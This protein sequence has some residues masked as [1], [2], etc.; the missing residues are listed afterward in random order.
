MDAAKSV[1][2]EPRRL[3]PARFRELLADLVSA[4]ANED[5]MPEW[6][7]HGARLVALCARHF[8]H[9][10]LD[11]LKMWSRIETAMSSAV[12]KAPNGCADVLVSCALEHVKADGGFVA[13][14]PEVGDL[15]RSITSRTATWRSGFATYLRTA[16][17]TAMV[18]GR[19]LHE[20]R[21][22]ARS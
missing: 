7:D 13:S 22:E 19:D 20:Q 14:N 21:K 16:L 1:A 11:S 5:A 18:F 10:E 4:E 3:D 17:Y 15:I 8:N 6:R 9:D 2:P 12:A